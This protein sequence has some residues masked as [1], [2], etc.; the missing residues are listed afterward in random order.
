MLSIERRRKIIS[1]LQEHQSVIVPELSKL[2]KVT[3][4]TIRRD[5]EKLEREGLIKRSYGGAVLS[6]STNVDIPL[7]IREITNIEGKQAIA[8]NVAGYIDDGETLI[9]DSSS[10]ALQVARQLK[11]KKRLTVITNSIRVVYELSNSKDFNI[12]STGGTLKPNSLSFIGH[13]AENT[14]KN[15]HVDKAIISCKGFNKEIGIT[16]SNEMEAE[17]KKAMVDAADQVFLLI[18]HTKVDRASFVKFTSFDRIN[19][20]FT[21]RKFSPDWEDLIHKNNI[22]IIY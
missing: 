9:L 19:Y 15:Y 11:S 20:I 8:L 17:V 7:K 3:E 2:F 6:E 22:N 18:D 12:I 1:L 10:S 16:D 5:L 13:L 21:D 4:E 14:I